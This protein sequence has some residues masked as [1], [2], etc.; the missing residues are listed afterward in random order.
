MLRTSFLLALM[1]AFVSLMFCTVTSFGSGHI[2]ATYAYNP[3]DSLKGLS[4]D[5]EKDF[6]DYEI[7][8]DGT[9]Q[10]GD[11][12]EGDAHFAI[13][14]DFGPIQLKPFS[15]INVIRT[16]DW[17]HTLDGGLKLNVP[18]GDLDIA[19]GVFGRNS[20]SFVPLQQGTRN[21]VTG[22]VTWEDSTLLDF[23]ELGVL[24]ALL[25]TKFTWERID[26]GVTGIVDVSN[27]KFHQLIT[28][29]G[30]SWDV[31]EDLLLTLVAEY[32]TQAGENGGQQLDFMLA[33]GYQF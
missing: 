19:V 25:E 31:S 26:I 14:F 21:P 22:T 32:I 27:R 8:T 16:E 5:Y 11:I 15:E 24:N 17:G 30:T 13:A 3:I 6:G 1:F 10:Q 4:A 9:I 7:E 18:L 12:V 2:S 23:N 28:E 33:F 20:N 29:V